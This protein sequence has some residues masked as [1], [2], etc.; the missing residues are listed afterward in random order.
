MLVSRFK[1]FQD[2]SFKFEF[3]DTVC[4]GW[5]IS[6]WGRAGRLAEATR[7]R[8]DLTACRP[9]H[10]LATC[11]LGG[12]PFGARFACLFVQQILSVA[13]GPREQLAQQLP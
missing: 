9:S 11:E 1:T 12:K 6:Q 3:D 10:V 4:T 2:G 5:W 8:D 7:G 13:A